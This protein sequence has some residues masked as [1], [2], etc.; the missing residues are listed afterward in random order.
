MKAAY[1]ETFDPARLSR[2]T[3]EIELINRISDATSPAGAITLLE[4]V[5]SVEDM[6]RARLVA[7]AGG[8]RAIALVKHKGHKALELARSGVPITSAL[9]LQIMLLVAVS[10][11]LILAFLAVLQRSISNRPRKAAIY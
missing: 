8:D 10:I 7:E 11:A 6:R 1:G 5:Q 3:I 9:I 4:H 2:L